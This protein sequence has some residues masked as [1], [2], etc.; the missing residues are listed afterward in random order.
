[1]TDDIE[2]EIRRTIADILQLPTENVQ[3]T[4]DFLGLGGA[5]LAVIDLA[6]WIHSAYGVELSLDDIFEATSIQQIVDSVR[7][8][9]AQLGH[10]AGHG[11]LR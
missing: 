7:A 2:N 10:T 6:R 9:V 5:S 8:E 1:V 4:D 3:L 11:N